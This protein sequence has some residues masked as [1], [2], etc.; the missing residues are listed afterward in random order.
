MLLLCLRVIGEPGGTTGFADAEAGAVPALVGDDQ[1]D[2]LLVGKGHLRSAE[3]IP[4]KIPVEQFRQLCT[5]SV[6]N[7]LVSVLILQTPTGLRREGGRI[8]QFVDLQVAAADR[9]LRVRE[10]ASY[11]DRLVQAN[12]RAEWAAYVAI[13]NAVKASFCRTRCCQPVKE[14]S[15]YAIR[16]LINDE[17]SSGAY[18][19]SA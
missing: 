16:L 1:L 10:R 19:L 8:E 3:S 12:I 17:N 13:A 5:G 9:A 18:S 6:G 11:I 2:T 15:S 4:V 7:V 14:D